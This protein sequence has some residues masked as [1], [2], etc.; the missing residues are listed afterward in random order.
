[1]CKTNCSSTTRNLALLI[2]RVFVGGTFVFHGVLKAMQMDQ[3][4]G[5]F[6][7]IGF[8]AM[9]AYIA[10]YAEIIGGAL[11]VLGIFTL[12]G[13][14]LVGAV[15]A[16]AAFKVKWTLPG[17]PFIGRYLASELDLS[18]LVSAITLGLM[19]SGSWSLSRWCKCGCHKADQ[20]NC[21][22]CTAVGCETCSVDKS[23]SDTTPTV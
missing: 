13:A 3:T 8:S 1:M 20:A 4:V 12:Y 17:M 23:S 15:M 10:T 21:G 6:S 19:G 14:I 9:W 18:L 2:L 16:V 7:Q 11:L 5:F 22:V